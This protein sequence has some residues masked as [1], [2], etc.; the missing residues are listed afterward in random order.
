MNKS[1]KMMNKSGTY[2]WLKRNCDQVALA[3][4]YEGQ[5]LFYGELHGHRIRLDPDGSIDVGYKDFDRWANSLALSFVPTSN[6]S[7]EMNMAIDKAREMEKT[8]GDPW[9]RSMKIVAEMIKEE[10]F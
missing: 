1:G 7:K 3:E 5:Y 4:I 10:E 8:A 2:H 9:Q 6:L